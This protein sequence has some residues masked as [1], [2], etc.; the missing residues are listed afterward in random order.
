MTIGI[1]IK[2][3]RKA[4]KMSQRRLAE[5]TG[6]S[7][8]AI[9]KYERDLDIPGSATLR[10]LIQALDVPID[11]L[12][13]PATVSVQLRAYRKHAS[14]GIKE[15]EAIQMRIQEWL[16]RYIEVENL[17]ELNKIEP[18]LPNYKI[19]AIN[20]VEDAA[21]NLRNAW[22]LGLNPIENL[23]LTLEDRGIKVGQVSGFSHFD[24]CTFLVEKEPVIVTKS[25]LPGD[26]QRFNLGHELGHLILD[27]AD[28]LDSEKI[29][30]RFAGAFLAPDQ[31]TFFELGIDRT[32]L[33][34]NELYMLKHKYGMSMQ[35][36]IYR[37]KDLKIISQRTAEVLFH[38]F[39]A[40]NW[41]KSEPGKEFPP[42]MPLR[43]ERLVYRALAEDMISR[44][45]AQ[46]LLG[47]SLQ[48][49]WIE[50][51]LSND[52]AVGADH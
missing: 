15:Q 34:F 29:C 13:R 47:K 32:S 2:Q 23:T 7:A 20:E 16:E 17:L 9:S 30:K 38:K 12:F 40:N 4:N 5:K 27:I 33:D 36:W 45:K 44:S 35:A 48:E 3:A 39:R 22:S 11:F 18:F 50:E 49:R 28:N 8:M 6:V 24:A 46:E 52:I 41:N 31:A 51:K 25:D 42:E 10:S 21:K 37:A 1:R 14:L 19:I 43:M 26:R